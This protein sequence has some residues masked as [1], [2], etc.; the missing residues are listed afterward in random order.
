MAI[1][2]TASSRMKKKRK[3]PPA[4][5]PKQR[6]S[7]RGA[8]RIP[9]EQW[10][11]PAGYTADGKRLANLREMVDPD[12][13][14]ISLAQ[15][16]PVQRAELVAERIARQPKFQ[17]AMLGAGVVD[18]ERAISEVKAQTEIGRALMEI[19]QNAIHMLVE[20]AARPRA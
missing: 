14:T 18:Q 1:S 3:S 2:I 12:V 7:S 13:P 17:L 16:T 20:A 6:S 11:F 15:L 5:T 8:I 9:P 4:A 10:D 19:E